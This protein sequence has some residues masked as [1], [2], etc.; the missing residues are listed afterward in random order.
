VPFS[1]VSAHL[2][3]FF[4]DY[5]RGMAFAEPYHGGEMHK[6]KTTQLQKTIGSAILG[7]ALMLG[8]GFAMS[9]TV[10]AQNPWWQDRRDRDRDY[11]DRDRDYRNDRYRNNRR[12]GY[13]DGYPN[14]GGSFQL[15]QTALN[16][17]YNDGIKEGRKDRSRGRYRDLRDFNAYREA[18]HDYNSR[19]GDRY[20]HQQ[21]YR[22]A[23]ERGY[24]TGLQGY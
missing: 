6:M 16:A 7:L 3:G 20:L 1:A 18:T 8:V 24:E 13:N 22:M 5:R 10:Q 14:L 2:Y 17:G 4:G 23:F 15:R 21:Y 11:R 9:T 19:N 12:G